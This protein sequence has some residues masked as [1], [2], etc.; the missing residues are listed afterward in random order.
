MKL[1]NKNEIISINKE[2]WIPGIKK[3]I[4]EWEDFSESIFCERTE[5]KQSALDTANELR[6]FLYLVESNTLTRQQF[7]RYSFYMG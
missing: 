3:A 5:D 1:T 6:T 2:V 7:E 4:A